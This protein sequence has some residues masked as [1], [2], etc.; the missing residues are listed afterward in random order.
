MSVDSLEGKELS[1]NGFAYKDLQKTNRGAFASRGSSARNDK[2][3]QDSCRSSPS[4]ELSVVQEYIEPDNSNEMVSEMPVLSMDDP[5]PRTEKD[6]L[7]V[8][9]SSKKQYTS[10]DAALDKC[11]MLRACAKIVD[12]S[13]Y[14]GGSSARIDGDDDVCTPQLA[15]C[16]ELVGTRFLRRMVRILVV[17][18]VLLFFIV[19]L[20]ST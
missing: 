18:L 7:E 12:L 14:Q 19:T 1:F 17:R 2:T 20:S 8:N 9:Q 13:I 15:M 5:C 16:V 3:L 10:V 11:T 6:A 4:L